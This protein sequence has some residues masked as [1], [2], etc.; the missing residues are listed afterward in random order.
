ML[1]NLLHGAG[2]HLQDVVITEDLHGNVCPAHLDAEEV[3]L[4][5]GEWR[6]IVILQEHPVE[7]AS[8][9]NCN[10]HGARV[11]AFQD[12]MSWGGGLLTG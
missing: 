2:N 5:L 4:L 12:S 11:H 8:I 6:K 7:V 1:Q 9:C 10:L 3:P